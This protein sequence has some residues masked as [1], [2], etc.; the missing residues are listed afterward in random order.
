M[1]TRKLYATVTTAVDVNGLPLRIVVN[2]NGDE[3]ERHQV[4]RQK[5]F[6]H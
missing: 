4:G 2:E 5:Y 3:V 6:N 1:R